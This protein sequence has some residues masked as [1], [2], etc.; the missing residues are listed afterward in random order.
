LWP[1]QL[2]IAEF[3]QN[4]KVEK[5][6]ASEI[7]ELYKSAV[8]AESQTDCLARLEKIKE[9]RADV[10]GYIEG[11]PRSEWALSFAL[12]PTYGISS[13][14]AVGMSKRQVLHCVSHCLCVLHRG[15][16]QPDS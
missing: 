2:N 10:H 5:D 15:I 14:Q 7:L 16:S 12:A 1:I 4:R 9:L 6:T 8:Y 11:I 13:S 3:C